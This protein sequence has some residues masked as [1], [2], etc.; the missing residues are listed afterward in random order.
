VI[1]LILVV[2]GYRG[3]VAGWNLFWPGTDRNMPPLTGSQNDTKTAQ[4]KNF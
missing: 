2:I 4:D 3:A 1:S